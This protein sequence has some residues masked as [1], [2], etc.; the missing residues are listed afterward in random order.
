MGVGDFD[1]EALGKVLADKQIH[2]S[3]AIGE[4]TESIS[5]SGSARDLE[6]ML[7]LVYL[8]MT[9]P[10]ADP[11]A[12]KVWKHNTIERLT[13]M[14]RAPEATYSRES[15]AAL[16]KNN[17]R[18]KPPEPADVE[19]VDPDQALGFYRARFGDASDFTFV[20]VGAV[21]L[22]DAQALGRD[23]P[24]QPPRQGPQGDG[25]GPGDSQGGR[26]RDS[27]LESRAGEEGD[28]QSRVPR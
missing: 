4:S 8:G 16:F 11:Q 27:D 25:E 22:D 12:F 24:R 5:A 15:S 26:R 18:R 7:Q 1:V 23:L 2:V 9:S 14:Q 28:G 6:P 3:T 13:N 20:I 19:K 17:P 21:H 10:R